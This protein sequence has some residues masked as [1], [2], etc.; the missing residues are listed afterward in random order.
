MTLIVDASVMA[1]WFYPE[2]FSEQARTLL[3]QDRF[4]AAPAHASAEL[5]QVLARRVRDNLLPLAGM[6]D[7]LTGLARSVA[8]IPLAGLHRDAARLAS[9]TG[10]S[11]YD[12]LY[13]AAAKQWNAT[14][15]TADL[16]LIR[17]CAGSP[18][19]HSIVA[20]A[21]WDKPSQP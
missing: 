10:A 8:L 17:T 13:V 16:R 21:N 4:L 5:G 14:L 18:C 15:V 6:E 11:L 19:A 7:A 2:D 20:L 9:E 12:A 3:G 1:K